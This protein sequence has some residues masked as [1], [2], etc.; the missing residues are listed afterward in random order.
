MAPRR[1]G[2][3]LIDADAAW[4]TGSGGGGA[5]VPTG[6]GLG[7]GGRVACP[8]LSGLDVGLGLALAPGLGVVPELVLGLA[9]A[10]G[11]VLAF[12][13]ELV[14]GEGAVSLVAIRASPDAESPIGTSPARRITTMTA[15]GHGTRPSIR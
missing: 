1:G 2:G 14:V 11:L 15:C 8:V 6:V 4:L 9:L 3:G 10:S 5:G 13:T 7:V 12:A